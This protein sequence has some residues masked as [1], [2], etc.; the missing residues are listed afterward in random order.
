ME[1]NYNNT[2]EKDLNKQTPDLSK[3]TEEYSR[4]VE[5]SE[6]GTEMLDYGNGGP[7]AS[8]DDTTTKREGGETE[9]PTDGNDVDTGAGAGSTD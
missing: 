4:E 5:N 9:E 8:R 6:L 1:N 7:G 3:A 2:P